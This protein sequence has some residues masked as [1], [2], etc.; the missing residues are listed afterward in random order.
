[1]T[2]AFLHRNK[3]I[4]LDPILL[5]YLVE[6]LSEDAVLQILMSSIILHRMFESHFTLY[7]A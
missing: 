2:L 4:A 7:D 1:M 3:G 6:S 5:T